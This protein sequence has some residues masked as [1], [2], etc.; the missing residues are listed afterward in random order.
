MECAMMENVMG[1]EN[2]LFCHP[3]L[4]SLEECARW[5]EQQP[6]LKDAGQCPHLNRQCFLRNV[7]ISEAQSQNPASWSYPAGIFVTLYF[8]EHLVLLL[9][10]TSQGGRSRWPCVCCCRLGGEP[11]E[12]GPDRGHAA[13]HHLGQLQQPHRAAAQSALPMGDAPFRRVL[14]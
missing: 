1:S 11:A 5:F 8:G 2:E 9:W 13:R 14:F 4:E 7:R 10:D 6:L 3:K 12:Q